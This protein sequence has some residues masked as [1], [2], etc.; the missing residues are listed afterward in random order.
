MRSDF[1]IFF[2]KSQPLFEQSEFG[3]ALKNIVKS[4]KKAAFE[5]R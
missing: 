2:R 5:G 1:A 3:Q 4:G